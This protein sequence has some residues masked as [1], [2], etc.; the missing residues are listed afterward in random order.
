M[1][2][3]LKQP[4]QFDNEK[5]SETVSPKFHEFQEADNDSIKLRE[6]LFFTRIAC[7]AILTVI[8][9]F[10]LLTIKLS[11]LWAF[12]LAILLSL[13]VTSVVSSVISSLKY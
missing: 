10:L 7:F 6:L 4:Q 8:F 13:V 3:P 5:H 9:A 2:A 1:P 11:S 12:T